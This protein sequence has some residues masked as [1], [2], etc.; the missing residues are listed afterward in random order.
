M[1]VDG[2]GNHSARLVFDG[3]TKTLLLGSHL[4]SVPHGGRFDG[5]LGVLCALEVVQTIKEAGLTLP[6]NL[7]VIDLTD[8]EGAHVSFMGSRA[9]EWQA[10]R[11]GS[12]RRRIMG[13]LRSRPASNA[14]A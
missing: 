11:G 6:V 13:C 14:R 5:P 4:D 8:E 9:D 2:A 7:E 10:A 12:G 3:A 1:S